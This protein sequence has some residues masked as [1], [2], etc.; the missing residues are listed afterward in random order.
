MK[1]LST[2]QIREADAYTIL[3]E[4]IDS[5]DLM[6]R[7]ARRI[8]EWITA[9]FSPDEKYCIICGTGNNGGDGLVLARLLAAGGA[10]V[11]VYVIWYRDVASPDFKINLERLA[12]QGIVSPEDIRE[13]NTAIFKPDE[14]L[15]DA[16]FGSGLSRPV[17]GLAGDLIHSMN[18]AGA[19]IISIDVPSGLFCDQPTKAAEGAVVRAWHTLS[20]EFPKL[21]FLFA[22]NEAFVG[23]WSVLSIGLHPSFIKEVKTKHFL[24]EAREMAG[25]LRARKKFSHKGTYGHALII[26]GSIGKM[27]AAVLA[28]SACLRSGPGLVSLSLPSGASPILNTVCPE[29]MTIERP[30]DFQFLDNKLTA[31]FT[32]I[33]IGP[34]LGTDEATASALKFLI[35]SINIP[36]ILDA[37]ALNIIAE[38]ITWLAF[39][40]KG[41]VLT[42]HPKEFERLAG[43]S[44]N[45]FEQLLKQ[46]ELSVKFG[47][48]IILKGAHSC[49]STPDGNCYF[50]A[51]GNPGMATGGS[52]DA[53][54]GILAGLMAQGYSSLET[55]LLGTWIHGFAG[56]IALERSSWEALLP[57][58]IIAELGEAFALL[59]ESK[60]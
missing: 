44:S 54:T 53:L 46:I 12:E 29:V 26:A 47:V 36:L 4:P 21:A 19:R 17:K 1:I 51:T 20:F 11:R 43:K 40:P 5:I 52:G 31:A 41:S 34:G 33:A 57:S 58:D 9:S 10:K 27:G 42:P 3:N 30:G 55:A 59:K 14:I 37:D 56:D 2:P 35:Q 23:E 24:L 32:S 38:N 16:L 60:D 8:Y 48:Y 25:I 18:R 15:I 7:A 39:L 6:E 45:S 22:E 13:K 28:A 49:I 50:N